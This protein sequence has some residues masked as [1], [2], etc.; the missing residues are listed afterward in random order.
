M[1]KL[2]GVWG[3]EVEIGPY[4]AG[5][6]GDGFEE[7]G[8]SFIIKLVV[9][10]GQD[11]SYKMYVDRDSF[12]E[13][14]DLWMDK[15]VEYSVE[16][17]YKEFEAKGVGRKEADAM[18]KEA[19]GGSMEEYLRDTMSYYL[20]YEGLLDGM[21]KS[22]NYSVEGNK[23]YWDGYNSYDLFTVTEDTLNIEAPAGMESEEL[24]P[25]VTYPLVFTREGQQ[26]N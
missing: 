13:N 21:Q 26:L 22:G 19:F 1:E 25:G 6:L 17:F 20:D 3:L 4:L 2:F 18:I 8:G 12:K 14:F 23:I 10:F 7:F 15:F 5:E 16:M 24:L 11:G 9:E